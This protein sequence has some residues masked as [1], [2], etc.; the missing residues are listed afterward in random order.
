[1]MDFFAIKEQ[2]R[3]RPIH[4]CPGRYLLEGAENVP[5]GKLVGEKFP[6]LEY[7]VAT[8]PDR[9]FVV[10]LEEGGIISYLKPNNTYTHP[11]YRNNGFATIA[12]AQLIRE[13]FNRNIIPHWDAMNE[14]SAHLA[15]KLGYTLTDTYKVMR[16]KS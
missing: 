12:G 3:S 9:V 8:A 11:E 14:T 7:S 16:I 13:C 5:P 10:K 1:M 2:Y 4:G 6:V 15:E